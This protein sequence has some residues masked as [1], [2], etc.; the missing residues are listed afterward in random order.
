M[1]ELTP[2]GFDFGNTSAKV[3]IGVENGRRFAK[4]PSRVGLEKPQ[5]AIS[6]K[7]GLELKAA[8]FSLVFN[9]DDTFWFGQDVLGASAIQKLDMSKYDADHISILFRAVL[10]QWQK[11]HKI[12]LSTLG[13]LNVVTSMPPGLFQKSASNNQ[14][15]TAFKKSFN[16]GQSHVWIRDGKSSVQ[17]VTQFG[18][19]I[20][21]AVAWGSDLPRHGKMILTVDM[22]GLTNDYALFNGSSTPVSS[23]TDKAGLLH[24]YAA[25]GSNAAQAEL[26]I[27]RNKNKQLPAPLVAYYNEVE[28]KIQLI[29][30]FIKRDIDHLYIIG[31]GA[32]LMPAHIKATFSSLAGK[33]TVK[34]EYANCEANWRHAGR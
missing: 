31:G 34:N 29:K 33:I 13:K 26:N 32:A 4:I 5:G 11:V 20:Q 6:S 15:V 16:R 25:I 23:R 17:I 19:L 10:Y 14:A 7:T 21:E 2:I 28:N 8:A 9:S 24:A 3:C 18:G 22:G 12:D 1:T 30:A 27:L